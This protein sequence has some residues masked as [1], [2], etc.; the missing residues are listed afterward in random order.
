MGRKR[1]I[2]KRRQNPAATPEMIIAANI[3]RAV[4]DN[5]PPGPMRT[6]ADI[7]AQIAE[8]EMAIPSIRAAYEADAPKT[9]VIQLTKQSDGS[10]K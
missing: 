1:Q 5:T 10:Y 3:A 7:V 9:P 8:A 2:T 4:A 6:V